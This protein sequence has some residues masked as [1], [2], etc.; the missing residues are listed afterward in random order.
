METLSDSVPG[1]SS[2]HLRIVQGILRVM[3]RPCLQE[4]GGQRRAGIERRVWSR[5]G[6]LRT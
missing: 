6:G 2:G 5:Y 4:R 1:A 3:Q